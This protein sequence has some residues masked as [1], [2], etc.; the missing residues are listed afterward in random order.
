M[1]SPARRLTDLA[2]RNLKAKPTRQELPDGGQRGLYL[3]IHPTGRRSFCC[4]YQFNGVSRK[5]TLKS[6]LSL[7]DARKAAADAMYM[8]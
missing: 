6:G 3:I 4:R 7:A 5:L 1:A 2:I 8:V